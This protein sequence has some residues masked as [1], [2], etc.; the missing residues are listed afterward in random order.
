MKQASSYY[1]D[2]PFNHAQKVKMRLSRNFDLLFAN[3]DSH[4]GVYRIYVTISLLFL[5]FLLEDLMKADIRKLKSQLKKQY[6][7][8]LWQHSTSESISIMFI[9]NKHEL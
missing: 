6:K 4:M 1:P 5:T 9:N 8:R 2:L 3:S 7:K